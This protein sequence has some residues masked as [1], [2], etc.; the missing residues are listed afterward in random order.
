MSGILRPM[1]GDMTGYDFLAGKDANYVRA[2]NE[3]VA[4]IAR[5]F[6]AAASKIGPLRVEHSA[7]SK[8]VL[9]NVE[10]SR[11]FDPVRR[12]DP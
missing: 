8:T 6:S 3:A 9:E 4:T 10:G 7:R 1:D 2:W 11:A 5:E 12:R